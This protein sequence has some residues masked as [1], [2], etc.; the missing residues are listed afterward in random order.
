MGQGVLYEVMNMAALWKLPVLY[1]CE[2]N[3]YTEYTFYREVVAGE[4]K[5]RPA[6][7]GILTEEVDGQDVRCV[8]T[9]AMRLVERARRGEGPGFLIC[10]T[11]RYHGHHVGDINRGYYRAK[12]K[13]RSGTTNTIPSKCLQAGYPPRMQSRYRYSIPSK[14]R[15]AARSKLLSILP[16]RRHSLIRARL[17][18]MS[19]LEGSKKQ[20]Y[21]DH[22]RDHLQPGRA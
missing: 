9:T 16:Y 18:K 1:V 3:L 14:T 15:C 7:F 20:Y 2:N 6:A 17:P 12:K 11:Y 19:T 10:N 5:D 4:L 22:A 13:R 21:Y 8:Y